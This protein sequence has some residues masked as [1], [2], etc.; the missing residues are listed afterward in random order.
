MQIQNS[1][2]TLSSGKILLANRGIIG[3][4]PEMILTEGYDGEFWEPENEFLTK[5]ELTEIA[6]Y[7]ISAWKSFR[8]LHA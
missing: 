6:D 3:L 8:N 5:D 1:M 7:M 2:V 4:T